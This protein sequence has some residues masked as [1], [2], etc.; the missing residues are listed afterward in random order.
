MSREERRQ[1]RRLMKGVDPLAPPI[2]RGAARRME[3]ARQ[4]RAASAG[5]PGRLTRRY[6]VVSLVLAGL[7]G[8]AALSMAW[9]NG[10]AGASALGAAAGLLVFALALGLRLLGRRRAAR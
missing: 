6:V 4:R 5:E 10:A 8:L 2:P 1:Y 9:P 3:R 7:V